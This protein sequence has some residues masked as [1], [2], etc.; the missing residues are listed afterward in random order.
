MNSKIINRVRERERY[1][2]C[3]SAVRTKLFELIETEQDPG[4]IYIVAR[5]AALAGITLEELRKVRRS[6]PF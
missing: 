6:V 5:L 2:S 3:L 4:S 1:R